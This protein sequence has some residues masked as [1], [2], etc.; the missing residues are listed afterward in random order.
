CSPRYLKLKPVAAFSPWRPW[1][2]R[3]QPRSPTSPEGWS[4][5]PWLLL[6][7]PSA[8]IITWK[9]TAMWGRSQPEGKKQLA[10]R[11]F[12]PRPGCRAPQALIVRGKALSL[13]ERLGVG[14]E[15]P[16]VEPEQRDIA[17]RRLGAHGGEQRGAR[18]S[19][20]M[21]GAH[22]DLVDV[23]HVVGIPPRRL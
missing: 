14:I 6:P 3:P 15:R 21:R 22:A 17:A 8:Q 16:D 5:L 11:A 1:A 12:S 7:R 4:I 13:E 19:A 23:D 2:A 20:T 9:Q 18:A 10:S